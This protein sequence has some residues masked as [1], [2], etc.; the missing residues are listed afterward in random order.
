M[1]NKRKYDDRETAAIDNTVASGELI[2]LDRGGDVILVISSPPTTENPSTKRFLADSGHLILASRYFEA[3]FKTIYGE[4][5]QVQDGRCPEIPLRDDDVEAMGVILNKLHHINLPNHRFLDAMTV[6]AVARQCDKYALTEALGGWMHRW[7]ELG[8][9]MLFDADDHASLAVAAHIFQEADLLERVAVNA[10]YALNA[11]QSEKFQ[12]KVQT[13]TGR[14]VRGTCN[15]S[16]F[17]YS[18]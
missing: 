4:G 12:R 14:Y 17:N 7:V 2:Y 15:S 18:N 9:H 6:E 10:T 1:A 16:F 3:R 13:I 5:Q 8:L 11:E